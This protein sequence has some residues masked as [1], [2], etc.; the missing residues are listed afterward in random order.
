[1][2][3]SKKIHEHFKNRFAVNKKVFVLVII[4]TSMM[5]FKTNLNTLSNEINS[6]N[7]QVNVNGIDS[8]K[9]Q[10]VFMLFNTDEGFPKEVNKA[11]KKGYVKQFSK[12]TSYTFENVPH[13]T[14]AVVIFHDEN[15]D[16]EIESNFIGMPKERV[17]A[18]NLTKRSKPNFKKC[19]IELNGVEKVI[20]VVFII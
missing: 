1:M 4:A 8:K 16:G 11:Y 2:K 13:G 10:I 9:G 18:S 17:G 12:S 6:G 19:A 20:D 5:S 7:I 3:F 15:N 14:Y